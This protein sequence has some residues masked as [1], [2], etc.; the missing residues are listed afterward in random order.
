MVSR[1]VHPSCRACG[2]SLVVPRTSPCFLLCSTDCHIQNR[3][4]LLFALWGA[5]V[6]FVQALQS[7]LD[8]F[9]AMDGG[10]GVGGVGGEPS[11]FQPGE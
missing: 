6:C 10:G 2:C 9:K 3:S 7:T 11:I 1:F 5:N 4:D 8:M